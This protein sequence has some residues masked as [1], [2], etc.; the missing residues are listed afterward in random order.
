MRAASANFQFVRSKNSEGR[1]VTHDTT[2]P[3]DEMAR[4]LNSA[5]PRL[6][7]HFSGNTY[8]DRTLWQD[9]VLPPSFLNLLEIN[10]S[11]QTSREN[12]A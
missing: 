12:I 1:R 2:P 9:R 7:V 6:L 5:D 4:P 11:H 8:L 10:A 3:T